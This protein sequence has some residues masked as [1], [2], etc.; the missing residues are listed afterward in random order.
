MSISLL[1]P[2]DLNGAS[3]RHILV[4]CE[5]QQLDQGETALE[6][7]CETRGSSVLSKVANSL[8]KS[9]AY[10][11]AWDLL[12]PALSPVDTSAKERGNT[13]VAPVCRNLTIY[14]QKCCVDWS[15]DCAVALLQ[16][17][18]DRETPGPEAMLLLC[19]RG[20]AEQPQCCHEKLIS[21]TLIL[22]IQQEFGLLLFKNQSL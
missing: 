12:K 1:C 14:P 10:W 19:S 7:E 3:S 6:R 4:T 17:F 18:W 2:W 16:M 8:E 15:R 21:L 20:R 11:Q 9:P 13:S 5:R 22:L